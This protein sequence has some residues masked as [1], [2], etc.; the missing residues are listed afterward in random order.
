MMRAF[1]IHTFQS[2][3]WKIDSVFDDRQ[4]ALFEAKR[5]DESSRYTGIRVVEESYDEKTD[6]TA[7]RT[8]FRDSKIRE[9]NDAAMEKNRQ[10]RIK[11]TNDRRKRAQDEV[12]R[13]RKT[14]QAKKRKESNPWRLIAILLILA[15]VA[16]GGLFGLQHL[17]TMI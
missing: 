8:I 9:E 4:L 13:K 17:Q 15:L 2:G 7:T 3:Q 6:R 12:V 16:V 11:A 5:M 14:V 10:T 1:E